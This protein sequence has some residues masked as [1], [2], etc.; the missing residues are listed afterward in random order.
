MFYMSSDN[1]SCI[2]G[3]NLNCSW[4]TV[5]LSHIYRRTNFDVGNKMLNFNSILLWKGKTFKMQTGMFKPQLLVDG[6]FTEFP[7]SFE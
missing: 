4:H 6:L 2:E 5:F 3:M 7:K 1:F